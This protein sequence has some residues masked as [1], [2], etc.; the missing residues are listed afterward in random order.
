MDCHSCVRRREVGRLDV[1]AIEPPAASSAWNNK[2]GKSPGRGKAAIAANWRSSKCPTRRRNARASCTSTDN[3]L[4]SNSGASRNRMSRLC[5]GS[6]VAARSAHQGRLPWRRYWSNNSNCEAI[7]GVG[8]PDSCRP[9][10]SAKPRRRDSPNLASNSSSS[11]SGS[12]RPKSNSS[13]SIRCRRSD[14][15][16]SSQQRSISASALR[17]IWLAS[18]CNCHAPSW[19]AIVSSSVCRKMTWR[20]ELMMSFSPSWWA[21]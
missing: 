11:R 7:I 20:C 5:C 1:R 2:A 12:K 8:S 10:C 16:S 21:E 9:I 19:L 18:C 17:M 15:L 3:C 4:S 14:A 6:S 13:R